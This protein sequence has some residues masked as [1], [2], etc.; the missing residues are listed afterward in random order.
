[1]EIDLYWFKQKDLKKSVH[2][3]WDRFQPLYAGVSGYRG[4]ILNFGW[5]V[6]P[7]MEWSGH[8][9]QRISLPTGSGQSRWVDQSAPLT[10]TTA[11]RKQKSEAR[12]EGSIVST[13]RGYDPWTYGDVKQLI[14][15]I[16]REAAR[17]GISGFKVGMLN[18]AWTDAY[19]EEAA[20]VSRHPEAFTKPAPSLPLD[21]EPNRYFDPAAHLH[22]DS[23]LLGGL[24]DGI[25]EGMPVHRAYAAQWGS[26]SR[27]LGLDAIMLR[28]S[29]G[30]P[31]PYERGGPWGPLAPSAEIVHQATEAVAA[32]V[33][34]T[35]LANPHAL[36]MMYSNAASA[37]AD[38]PS[39]GFDLETIAKQGYLDI[40]VDQTWAGA[41]NEVGIRYKNFW[42]NPTLG[43]TYQLDY[44]LA[45]AA[46]L[47]DTKVRHYP[48]V[49]TFDAWESWDVIHSAPQRLRWGIW[50]YS[51]AAV[52]TPN[53][54][55]MPVGSYISWANQGDRLLSEADV[56][57]LASN[58]NAAV[59][60]AHKTT[61][62]FGPTLVYSRQAMQW[63]TDRASPGQDANEWLDEQAGS[64][65][66]WPVPILSATRVEWLPRVQSDLFLIQTPSH[67]S[68]TRLDALKKLIKGG[69]PVALVGNFAGSIDNSL[70][71]LA[72]LHGGST[73]VEKP[74][75]MCKASTQALEL[76]KNIPPTFS[77]YCRPESGSP[78]ADT[79][80]IYTEEGS[81]ALTLKETGGLLA[82]AWNAPDLM[83]LQDI[84]LSRIWGN[85][86]APYALAAGTL[87]EML[88]RNASLHASQIDLNQTMSIAAWRTTNGTIHLL[89]GNL[90]E[91]LRDDADLSRHATLAIPKSWRGES[92]KDAWTGQKSSFKDGQ[93]QIDLSQASSALLESSQ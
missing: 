37:V 72:G 42:N 20:W 61:T 25:A 75:R 6:G 43:W 1:M 17:R 76:V 52:K 67:L 2:E 7:V 81:P 49:E 93:L 36:V 35:K 66:K 87:N 60:D 80:V 32:L 82:A 88:R 92:W 11:E 79:T 44:M 63:Q 45:H 55:K 31:V 85:T 90:E 3:F 58:I 53:G 39:N 74:I 48:L 69:Q 26:I 50:A 62:V 18:Y 59:A 73:F 40:W 41:W 65:A 68:A 57:F 54:L 14:A 22:A 38:W 21:Q 46:I 91:G 4:V 12:Y 24:P 47:A 9:D 89:A 33:K 56:N 8:L 27:A 29:F 84:P 30:M 10:G 78:A 15:E 70:L 51:H 16:K 64:L 71:Q 23:T 28:D 83:S 34:E 86:G 77:T 13:R 19:G 5:T